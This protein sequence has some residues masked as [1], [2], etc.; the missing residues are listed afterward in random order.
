MIDVDEFMSDGFAKIEEAAPRAVADAARAL[1]WEQLG[2]P[3]DQP[4]AWSKPT[5]WASDLTGAGPFGE[6]VRSPRLAAALDQICG[7]GGWQ[8]R[9]AL[10]TI[11][12]RFPVAPPD[13]DRGWHI[14]LNTLLP[15]GTWSVTGR[16]HTLLLL[17]LLSDTGADDAPTRIRRGSHHDVAKVLD[18]HPLD[19][20]QASLLVDDVTA[21]RPVAH[22]TGRPGDM[23]LVHPFTVHA[24]DE[25]R[26]LT[27]RFMAQSPVLLT[28]PLTPST[29]SPLAR[30]FTTA[31]T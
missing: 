7:P 8:P 19:A 28:E 16:P 4:A 2:L 12:V 25:H 6:L 23:Y 30:V 20:V 3:P 21:H 10:G 18:E 15:D 13:D 31:G 5:M 1:L 9:W 14:D 22:A 11:P 29:P 27:P 17:T 26:G 24:A